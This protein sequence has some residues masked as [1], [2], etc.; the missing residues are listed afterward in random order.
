MIFWSID[1]QC[2]ITIFL[3]H[4]CSVLLRMIICSVWRRLS[5]RQHD[6]ETFTELWQWLTLRHWFALLTDQGTEKPSAY[7]FDVTAK[8][9]TDKSIWTFTCMPLLLL[10]PLVQTVFSIIHRSP[11]GTYCR[12]ALQLISIKIYKKIKT[13]QLLLSQ[14]LWLFS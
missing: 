1:F 13:F 2:G 12:S 7:L 11:G 4:N 14:I 9:C 8:E 3:P 6:E 5:C 10:S